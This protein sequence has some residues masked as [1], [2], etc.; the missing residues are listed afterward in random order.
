MTGLNTCCTAFPRKP[1]PG[2]SGRGL[3]DES[4]NITWLCGFEREVPCIDNFL[5]APNP[6]GLWYLAS[7][8]T[9]LLGAKPL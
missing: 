7:P 1:D 2:G 6:S 5:E 3:R 8:T 4:Y 9:P